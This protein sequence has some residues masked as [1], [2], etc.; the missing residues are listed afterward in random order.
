MTTMLTDLKAT[1]L[2]LPP[3]ATLG[4]F[5]TLQKQVKAPVAVCPPSKPY[6]LLGLQCVSCNQTGASYFDLQSQ[7]CTGCPSGL[8]YNSIT[9][10]CTPPINITNTKALL[11][12]FGSKNYTLNNLTV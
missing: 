1:K 2:I 4:S 11:N 12:Y 9:L 3:N 8:F 10:N 6:S 5:A 7:T